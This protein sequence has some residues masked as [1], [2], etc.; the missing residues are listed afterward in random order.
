[1]PK[2]YVIIENVVDLA[3]DDVVETCIL[4]FVL[5]NE[6]SKFL[7]K[8]M[9]QRSKEQTLNHLRFDDGSIWYQVGPTGYLLYAEE[10]KKL[11]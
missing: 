7:D 11:I 8:E 1:M 4:G 6:V 9:K 2:I 3:Y 5:Q 10:L